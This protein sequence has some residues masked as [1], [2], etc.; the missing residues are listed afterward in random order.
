MTVISWITHVLFHRWEK[1]CENGPLI[2]SQGVLPC[3]YYWTHKCQDCTRTKR[4]VE[5]S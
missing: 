3:G 1:D 4:I 5:F 2:P